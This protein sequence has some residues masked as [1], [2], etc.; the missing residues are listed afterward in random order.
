MILFTC[1]GQGN[2]LLHSELQLG[3]A[4]GG[5]IFL[6]F[7][8]NCKNSHIETFRFDEITV[9]HLGKEVPNGTEILKV[10]QKF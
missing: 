7:Y 10:E 3:G 2:I 6:S 9:G 8:N 4:V 1:T 5:M